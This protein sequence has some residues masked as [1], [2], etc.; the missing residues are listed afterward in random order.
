MS[1]DK[2]DLKKS[3]CAVQSTGRLYVTAD[4]G[5]GA[6]ISL[7]KAQGHYLRNV[8][9]LE[10]G[11]QIS[12]FNGRDGEWGAALGGGKSAPTLILGEKIRDQ[13]MA[14]DIWLLFAPIKN[15][16]QTF[17][18]EK[19]TELGVSRLCPVMTRHTAVSRVNVERMAANVLEAAEQSGRLSVPQ[20]DAPQKLESV[21][22][23]WDPTRRLILC[24]ESGTAA[25]MA[26]AL[27]GLETHVPG[28]FAILTGPEGGFAADE[29]AFLRERP[30]VTAVSL[31]PRLLRADTAVLA[32][33]SCFR[34]ILG[35]WG[36]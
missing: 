7:T 35:D 21:M 31:G 23:G 15:T 20:V 3:A 24:D 14:G 36:R 18:V 28:G 6:Q 32:A 13:D 19:A 9:R 5:V 33:L 4:L 1:G 26:T 17:M 16:P 12:V 25:P 22:T 2:K 8:L 34:A 11:A 29:L 10:N 30:F 27:E